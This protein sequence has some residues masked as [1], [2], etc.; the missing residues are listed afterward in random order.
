M[1][2]LA[3]GLNHQTASVAIR[4][5]FFVSHTMLTDVL[6]S[7]QKTD[8]T[9]AVLLSTCNRTELYCI[10]EHSERAI[11]ALC[12]LCRVDAKTV[13]AIWYI[14]HDQAALRHLVAVAAGL[15]SMIL[16]E[17]QIF[18]QVKEAYA[19]A[20]QAHTVGKM[21]HQTFQYCFYLAKK[22]RSET[23]IGKN[24]VSV[25]FAASTLAKHIFADPAQCNITLIGAGNTIELTARHFQKQGVQHFNFVNRTMARAAHLAE[26]FQGSAFAL[27]EI[28]YAL[29]EADIIVTATE[30]QQH[31]I[32]Y[33]LLE[34]ITAHHTATRPILLLD[35]SIPRNIEPKIA[36][37]AD[38]YLYGI[39]DLQSVVLE[40]F[41]K[42]RDA[43]KLAEEIIA[44]EV[45]QFFIKQKNVRTAANIHQFNEQIIQL[46]TDFEQ[47]IKKI[48]NA[49]EVI[50]TAKKLTK[51]L[52]HKLLK[53]LHL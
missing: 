15:D 47:D 3:I 38:C 18:G 36:N 22:V 52:Q 5:Q 13:T 30:S 4:E 29:A 17:P 12:Q 6:L 23:H 1:P 20:Q 51:N 34:K 46:L 43:A 14:Y 48:S 2:L 24:P 50:K 45:E 39:D 9:E 7:L 32:T 53:F 49:D 27:S 41:E 25:A 35:L 40:N 31:L 28:P 8:I 19:A 37:L 21:L 10:A 11:A 16:G 42:R 33:D 44:H 26:Q